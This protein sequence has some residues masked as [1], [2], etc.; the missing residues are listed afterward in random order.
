MWERLEPPGMW[1]YQ[2]MPVQVAMYLGE[3]LC[4]TPADSFQAWRSD[5][6]YRGGGG[7]GGQATFCSL[8]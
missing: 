8:H 1:T 4:A 6:A 7:G 2:V 5:A 3:G